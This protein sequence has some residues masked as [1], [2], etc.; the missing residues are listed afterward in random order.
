MSSA[1]CLTFKE[2][3]S[4]KHVRFGDSI[5]LPSFEE[6]GYL[7]HLLEYHAGGLDVLDRLVGCMQAVDELTQNLDTWRRSTSK[8][9]VYTMQ[10]T[11]L[12]FMQIQ[13]SRIHS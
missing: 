8:Y 2:V 10:I 13:Y 9:T 4:L 1:G 7:F 12:Y 11:M 3:Y 5:V 6:H